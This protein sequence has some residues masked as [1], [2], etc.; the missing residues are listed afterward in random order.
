MISRYP[1]FTIK[2]CTQ[3]GDDFKRK[4]CVSQM[5]TSASHKTEK[6]ALLIG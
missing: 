5:G 3:F 6:T 4:I 2:I 1:V